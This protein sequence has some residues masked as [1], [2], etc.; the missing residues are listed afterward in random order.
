MTHDDT[1]AR[2]KRALDEIGQKLEEFVGDV[3]KRFEGI[4]E[5]AC[6]GV[7]DNV[8]MVRVNDATLEKL[9]DLVQAELFRSRSEAAAFLIQAGI[10][11]QKPLYDQIAEKVEQI[12]KLR[13]ELKRMAGIGGERSA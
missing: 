5:A 12:K 7:R 10:Q 6:C 8:V 4:F 13:E 1:R 9:D 11:G 3:G 2:R